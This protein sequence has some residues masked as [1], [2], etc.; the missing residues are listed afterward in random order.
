MDIN[1]ENKSISNEPVAETTESVLSRNRKLHNCHAGERCFIIATGP[2]LS[3]QNLKLLKGEICIG[4]SNSFKH[5]DYGYIKPKYHCWAAYHRPETDEGWQII[6]KNLAE[7]S[8]DAGLFFAAADYDRNYG[9]EHFKG[10]ALHFLDYRGAW[11]EALENGLDLTMPVPPIQSGTIITLFIALYMGFKRIYLLGCDTNYMLSLSNNKRETKGHF[12]DAAP[13][14]IQGFDLEE[15]CL[16]IGKLCHQYKM[17]HH[18][19]KQRSV[20]IY[21]ATDGGLLDVFPRVDY[22]SL[23]NENKDTGATVVDAIDTNSMRGGNLDLQKKALNL[24]MQAMELLKDNKAEQALAFAEQAKKLGVEVSR[25]HYIRGLCLSSIGRYENAVE[26]FKS[27]LA[28]NPGHEGALKNANFL[29]EKLKT[30]KQGFATKEDIY[31]NILR[32]PCYTW[33]DMFK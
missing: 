8:V 3:N 6:M 9:R 18:I 4:L 5:E 29:M 32:L 31:N 19:A 27:E 17:V 2:S 13:G 15:Q 20:E 1:S 21:N 11:D 33:Y 24:S 16:C 7:A 10:R 23:F 26:A 12:F 30:L 25:M 14:V 22:E 28:I